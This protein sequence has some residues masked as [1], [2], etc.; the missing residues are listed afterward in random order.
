MEDPRE[1][2][3]NR[4]MLRVSRAQSNMIRQSLR[5]MVKQGNR[6]SLDSVSTSIEE[7]VLVEELL[8][9]TEFK[10]FKQNKIRTHK[11]V[12]MAAVLPPTDIWSFLESQK[13]SE[14]KAKEALDPSAGD[15]LIQDLVLFDSMLCCC[16]F[17]ILF[18]CN[19]ACYRSTASCV[20]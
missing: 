3:Q 11:I 1:G 19:V 2:G 16:Y 17:V 8:K 14:A 18:G 20:V 7:V 4:E 15:R 5:R 12:K 10:Q 9:S 6:G 13:E